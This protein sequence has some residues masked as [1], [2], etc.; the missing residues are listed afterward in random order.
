MNSDDPIVPGV[1]KKNAFVL[2]TDE[3][4][5]DSVF[6]H[7][8]MT[9]KLGDRGSSVDPDGRWLRLDLAAIASDAS[10]MGHTIGYVPRWSTWD[11]RTIPEF[12]LLPRIDSAQAR[13]EGYR[14]SMSEF[15]RRLSVAWSVIRF[16]DDDP[17]W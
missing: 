4:L 6:T 11:A 7:E 2:V 17:E 16:G 13:L 1:F 5:A 15:R 12:A 14:R 3:I 8:W 10:R 9:P